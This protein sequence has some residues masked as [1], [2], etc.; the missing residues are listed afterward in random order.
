V[1]W[2]NRSHQDRLHRQGHPVNPVRAAAPVNRV[3][4]TIQ[5]LLAGPR[6]VPVPP[7]SKH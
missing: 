7:V 4:P 1:V 2:A 6:A 3:G 5:G